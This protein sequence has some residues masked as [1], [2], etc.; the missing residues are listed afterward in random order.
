MEMSKKYFDI[1]KRKNLPLS[2]MVIDIDDF[3]FFNKKYGHHFAD[4]ILKAIASKI[5]SQIRGMDIIGRFGGDEFIIVSFS[6]QDEFLSLA[7]R[8]KNNVSTVRVKDK[9][10]D[11]SV[12]IGI[13]EMKMDD[14]LDK[15]IKRAEE[16]L[17]MAKQKGGNRVDYLEHFLLFE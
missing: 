10:L 15:V 11:V 8:I 16:A 17:V 3:K 12:S 14:S 6:S 2:V 9:T 4:Y 13:S 1:S 7:K 5:K